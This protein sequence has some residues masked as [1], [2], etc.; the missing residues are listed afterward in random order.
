[1]NMTFQK[2]NRWAI[3]DLQRRSIKKTVRITRRDAK[4]L[5][6]GLMGQLRE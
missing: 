4:E 3:G 2:L 6:D 1:M 5:W